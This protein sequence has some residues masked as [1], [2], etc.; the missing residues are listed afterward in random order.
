[1]VQQNVFQTRSANGPTSELLFLDTTQA[2]SNESTD[3]DSAEESLKKLNTEINQLLLRTD[4]DPLLDDPEV[5]G[6]N[7][8]ENTRNSAVVK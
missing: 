3:A 2:V 7:A 5:D 8:E 6:Q 4:F 1:M